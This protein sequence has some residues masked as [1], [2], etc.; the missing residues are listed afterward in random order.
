MENILPIGTV[1][2]LKN[3]SLKVMITAPYPSY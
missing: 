1:V 2:T 3:G